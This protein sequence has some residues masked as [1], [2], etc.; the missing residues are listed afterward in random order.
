[1]NPAADPRERARAVRAMF[2]AIAPTYDLLNRILSLG[3]D[4]GWRRELVRRIPGEAR[5]VLDL[6]C[7]TGDVA[8]E[9]RKQRPEA[10]VYGADFALPMLRAGVPKL[11]RRG[12]DGSI[13]LQNASAEDLPYASDTFDAATIAFGIRN[14]A[15]RE[16]ALGELHRVLRPGGVLLVLDFSLPRSAGLAALYRVYFHRMLPFVG[17]VISGNFEAYRYLPRSVEGFPPRFRF[18]AMMTRA[19]FGRVSYRDLTFGIV[20]LYEATKPMREVTR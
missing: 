5:R 7:G 1:M 4:R 12:A 14:V 6:A 13:L 15:R 18:A 2:S 11:R 8:L 10:R 3:I 20:T 17:G 9:I 19:G 16:R